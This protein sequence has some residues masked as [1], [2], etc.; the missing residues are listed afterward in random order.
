MNVIHD[1]LSSFSRHIF[2]EHVCDFLV[3]CYWNDYC[4]KFNISILISE[5]VDIHYEGQNLFTPHLSKSCK[6][7]CLEWLNLAWSYY[8]LEMSPLPLGM[9]VAVHCFDKHKPSNANIISSVVLRIVGPGV[10]SFSK[11]SFHP[12]SNFSNPVETSNFTVF[13]RV[14]AYLFPSIR[15]IFYLESI[16]YS[17]R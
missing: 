15:D 5:L 1:N 6:P 17:S 8:T 14:T 4:F 10:G 9:C 12:S 7:K 3:L 11:L 2:G 13:P 16:P